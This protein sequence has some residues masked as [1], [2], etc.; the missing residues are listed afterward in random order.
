M[1]RIHQGGDDVNCYNPELA[2]QSWCC[3]DFKL[4]RFDNYDRWVYKCCRCN[5]TV[6]LDEALKQ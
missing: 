2:V 4:L 1:G 3:H 6:T 5:L